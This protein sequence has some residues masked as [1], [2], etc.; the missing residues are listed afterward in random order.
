M[1]RSEAWLGKMVVWGL[2][3]SEEEGL[4]FG[5]DD[6]VLVVGGEAAVY[7]RLQNPNVA[8]AKSTGENTGPDVL[9]E[10]IGA[11]GTLAEAVNY[12]RRGGR[13]VVIGVC[14][15]EDHWGPIAAM[16]KE[17]DLRFSLGL[18]PG[19][20]ETTI[21]ML[22]CLPTDSPSISTASCARTSSCASAGSPVTM[23]GAPT[24]VS[25]PPVRWTSAG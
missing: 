9:F 17:L 19:E 22:A 24:N 20:I 2:G 11:A 23:T 7:T 3:G 6:G 1:K 21:A 15:E 5:N 25:V 18:E 4:A 8:L 12:A 16:N 14:M 10:C 13:V